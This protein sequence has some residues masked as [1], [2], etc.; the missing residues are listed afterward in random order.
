M[1]LYLF[2][3]M[4]LFL[5]HPT[6]A[7][8]IRS[9]KR[10]LPCANACSA[11]I[12]NSTSNEIRGTCSNGHC[13]C[14]KG[15]GGNDCSKTS[16]SPSIHPAT[17]MPMIDACTEE[18]CATT[19]TFGGSCVASTTCACFD[20]WGHGPPPDPET[21][22][23]PKNAEEKDDDESAGLTTVP[24]LIE[25]WPMLSS[26]RQ[27]LRAVLTAL[28]Y[29]A[30]IPKGNKDPCILPWVVSNHVAV[31]CNNH[32]RVT[33]I[34]FS[35]MS[36]KGQIPREITKLTA[37]RVLALNNNEITGVLPTDVGTL[38]HLE[39]LMLYKN[40]IT[41]TIPTSIVQCIR[42][43]TVILYGNHL[44]GS[45]P[46]TIGR[47]QGSL[48]YLD[49]SFNQMSGDLPASLGDLI[50]LDTMY[51]NHNNFIGVLPDDFIRLPKL[52][53]FRYEENNFKNTIK[54]I[55]NADVYSTPNHI[56]LADEYYK[57]WKEG[58]MFGSRKEKI[59]DEETKKREAF[60]ENQQSK[61]EGGANNLNKKGMAMLPPAFRPSGGGE[62][63]APK[64]LGTQVGGAPVL[65]GTR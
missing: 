5:P 32:G 62:D 1:N 7:A 41:G 18:V 19:C 56:H 53:K 52:K 48:R 44:T 10:T 4:V 55:G 46:S 47:L 15:F 29:T 39:Y 33:E 57:T 64:S 12:N 20:H 16:T 37:L 3:M 21:I 8:Y 34:D 43:I 58:I 61:K 22:A 11:S 25:R 13:V 26:D 50:N 42:L 23:T 2:S 14:F 9:T 30:P 31:L 63:E 40:Q 65:D 60:K 45:L 6:I 54:N 35:R 38:I 28:G 49:V 17:A 27:Q 59:F 51:I 36:L 24:L